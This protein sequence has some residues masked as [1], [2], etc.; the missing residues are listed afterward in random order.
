MNRRWWDVLAGLLVFAMG[1]ACLPPAIAQM[2]EVKE[3]PPMYTYVANWQ[4]PRAQWGEMDKSY[5]SDEKI[6]QQALADGTLVGYGNDE[7]L[8]HQ[9]DGATHDDWW[10]AMSMAGL[11]KVLNQ[12]YTSGTATA[13]V[14]A[15]A[16]KHW[17]GIYVSRY[18]NWKPGSWKGG[19]TYVA[20][21]KFKPNAPDD[22]LDTLCK[23]L[24]APLLEKL[25]ADGTLR[26]YEVDTEAVHTDD[27]DY[28]A[29]VYVATSP[30]GLDKVPAAIRA[31]LKTQPLSG[32]AFDSMVDYHPHRDYLSMGSGVYK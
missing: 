17:D 16:T 13:P 3:K 4:I 14:L 11:M 29:I 21:Y 22:A 20:L 26:E 1:A 2:S 8:V 25:V 23:N 6:L 30:D 10:S 7:T 12:F 24:I 27:P 19:Y 5:A 18:Y 31:T 15:S 28:F 32:P 9:T